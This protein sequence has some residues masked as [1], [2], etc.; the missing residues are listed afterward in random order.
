MAGASTWEGK[1]FLR[2]FKVRHIL[3]LMAKLGRAKPTPRART[4]YTTGASVLMSGLLITL[5]AWVI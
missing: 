4:L 5:S 2:I 1:L 3:I